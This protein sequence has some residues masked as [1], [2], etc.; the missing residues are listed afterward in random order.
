LTVPKT[1]EPSLKVAVPPAPVSVLVPSVSVAVK[2]TVAP[3]SEIV[4]A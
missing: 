3:V 2:E 4:D 1:L